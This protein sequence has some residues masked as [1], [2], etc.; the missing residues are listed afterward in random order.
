MRDEMGP[1]LRPPC[2]GRE[3]KAHARRKK[4]SRRNFSLGEK[5]GRWNPIQICSKE[6]GRKK[7]NSN[8]EGGTAINNSCAEERTGS[9]R[10]SEL[11]HH[12][13]HSWSPADYGAHTSEQP[14]IAR[15]PFRAD[16]EK[17]FVR[18]QS[19]KKR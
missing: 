11:R 5:E 1:A 6:K 10:R 4:Q 8:E 7:R 15:G 12:K 3:G 9:K 2:P 16:K 13:R 17:G 19:G 18:S 14:L